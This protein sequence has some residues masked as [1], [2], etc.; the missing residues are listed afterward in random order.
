M[1]EVTDP[2]AIDLSKVANRT[3]SWF[4]K[5]ISMLPYVCSIDVC[6]PADSQ[7]QDKSKELDDKHTCGC[8][9]LLTM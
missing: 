3:M 9:N 1:L 2:A 5:V 6:N 8:V 7:K 4:S